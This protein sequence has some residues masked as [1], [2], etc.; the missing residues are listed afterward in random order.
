MSQEENVQ[1]LIDRHFRLFW[2]I[3]LSR[4]VVDILEADSRQ[5]CYL[6]QLFDAKCKG[7]YFKNNPSQIGFKTGSF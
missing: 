7:K 2:I 6:G 3:I 5:T 4:N 1:F